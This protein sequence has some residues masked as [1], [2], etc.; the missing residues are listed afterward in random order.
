MLEL[1]IQQKQSIAEFRKTHNQYIL[2]DEA[3]ISLMQ[4]EM[5]TTGV[6]FK[7]FE[8][9]A[10]PK[11]EHKR[12]N[13]AF[14]RGFYDNETPGISVEKTTPYALPDIKIPE[15]HAQ[16][17]NFLK[18]IT[19][20]A[21]AV[22]QNHS[23]ENGTPM[24]LLND[25]WFEYFDKENAKSTVTNEISKTKS[26]I[27]VLEQAA[28]GAL[29]TTNY[30][31]GETK[32]VS[33]EETFKKQRGVEFNEEAIVEAQE[34][35]EE[36][37]RIKTVKSMVDKTKSEL[38]VLTK[39]DVKSQMGHAASVNG[40]LQA[41]KLSGVG[42]QKEINQIL[43]SISQKYE[44]H[45]D[46]KKYGGDFKLEKTKSGKWTITRTDKRGERSDAPNEE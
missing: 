45:P 34:K 10:A 43:K 36:F 9:L 22:V 38:A 7:G 2:N 46:V 16:T 19:G 11:D 13:S 44:D 1:S 20:E 37:S 17:I 24:E 15:A 6:V 28:N 35:A 21:Q 26:D 39:G 8:S 29:L 14:G 42:T 32:S 33:F 31:T 23:D 3:V 40:I 18:E 41:L 27:A 25:W 30:F 4:K 5:R 12:A